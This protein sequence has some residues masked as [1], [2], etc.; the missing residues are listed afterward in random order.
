MTF[1][2]VE[3]QRL[4]DNARVSL[5]GAL[6]TAITLEIFNVLSDFFDRTNCWWEDVTFGVTPANTRGSTIEVDTTEPGR[7]NRLL[8]VYVGDPNSTRSMTM[9]TPGTLM[10]LDVPGQNETWT[11]RCALSVLD[12]VPKNGELQGFPQAPDWVLTKY[13]VG[14]ASGVVSA[15]AAQP[16]KPYTNLKLAGLHQG[17]YQRVVSEAKTEA[18]RQNVFAAQAWRF[19][20]FA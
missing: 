5:P 13:G 11:A 2:L 3:T 18:R 9:P 20:A 7:M 14:L 10:F 12:P 16:S 8:G 6:D 19:P 15:M 1:K 17:R 4:L